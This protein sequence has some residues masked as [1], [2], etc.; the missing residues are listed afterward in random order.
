MRSSIV[1]IAVL[2]GVAGGS[3][4]PPRSSFIANMRA[5]YLVRMPG[6]DVTA[7]VNALRNNAPAQS[8]NF[9]VGEWRGDFGSAFTASASLYQ[10][11]VDDAR[12]KASAIALRMPARLTGVQSVTEFSGD[13]QAMAPVP[14]APVLKAINTVTI[15]N[16]IVTVAVVYRT[17]TA[18]T[19]AVFGR[20]DAAHSAPEGVSID[21]YANAASLSEARRRMQAAQSYITSTARQFH[22]PPAAITV[23]S[24]G[25]GG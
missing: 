24:A 13:T 17:D 12:R 10:A 21:V 7:F 19:I 20:A 14:G 3:S 15:E 4:P 6:Q 2:L 8:A 5:T 22:I 18:S 16:R 25:F 23:T 11:A 9:T 1:A